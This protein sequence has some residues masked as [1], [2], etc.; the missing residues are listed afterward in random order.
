MMIR[1]AGGV[2]ECGATI[3]CRRVSNITHSYNAWMKD[4]SLPAFSQ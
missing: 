3:F 4:E 2:Y 1:V